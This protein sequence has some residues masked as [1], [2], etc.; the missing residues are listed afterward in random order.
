MECFGGYEQAER[1]MVAFH[2]DALLFPWKYPIKCLKAE[3]LA[4]KIFRGPDAS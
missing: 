3:P 2:P 4:A 1:Q